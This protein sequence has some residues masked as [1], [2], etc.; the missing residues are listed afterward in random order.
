MN[1]M[2]KFVLAVLSLSSLASFAN[3][4]N[5]GPYLG[6]GLGGSRLETPNS[7]LFGAAPGSVTETSRKTGGLG[8]RVFAGYNFNNYFGLEAGLARYAQSKYKATMGSANSSINY[9]MNAI[10]I[11]AKAYLPIMDSGFNVYALGGVARASDTVQYKNGGV[12][13]ANGVNAPA[14]GSSTYHKFRPVYGI[15]AGYDIPQTQFTT[16]LE[17]SRIQ[18]SGNVKTN[19]SAIPSADLLSLNLAYNF[20]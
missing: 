17:F 11:V 14:A 12:P 6:A 19:S 13:L 3:A 1:K 20:G 18:G 4:A 15:G 8:G 5:P 7:F 10:D 16:N 2:V 9:T